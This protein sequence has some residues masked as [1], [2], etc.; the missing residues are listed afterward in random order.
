M[1]S[2][3]GAISHNM[4]FYFQ[5]SRSNY[6]VRR[7]QKLSPIAHNGFEELRCAVANASAISAQLQE[8]RSYQEDER[9]WVR[10]RGT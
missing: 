7:K 2:E 6:V 10:M 4:G 8:R 3:R 9:H 5:S 1:L